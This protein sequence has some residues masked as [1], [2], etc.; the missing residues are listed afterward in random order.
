MKI[1]KC[2]I[3]KSLDL[4]DD[5]MAKINA[6]TL[7]ELTAEEVFAFKMVACDNEID[8]DYEAF[9]GETLEQLA[10]LYKGKTVISDHNPQSTNQC[11]RIFDAEVITS[12]GE[13]TKTGK[14]INS[15]S[16]TAIALRRRAGSSSP[17]SRAASK[18]S[19]ASGAALNL[20]SALS[21]AATPDGASTIAANGTTARFAFISLSARSTLMRF[22]LSRFP[23]SARRA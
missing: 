19:A 23:H 21:A 13:T 2:A 5:K 11:A 12:P 7:K 14:S 22:L 6:C 20:R 18:R 1:D 8:R 15:L 4:D 17:K 10:E 16:Y 9:S 3:V